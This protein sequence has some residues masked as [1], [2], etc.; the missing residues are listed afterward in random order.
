VVLKGPRRERPLSAEG[1]DEVLSGARRR[2]G[3]EHATCHELRHTCLTRLREA[4]MAL[5][6]VQA[7]ARAPQYRVHPRLPAQA[8][9]SFAVLQADG[10]RI[11]A[12]PP[13]APGANAIG[14]RIIGMLRRELFDWL[15]IVNEQY[16]H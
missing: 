5:E 11:L 13:Q 14:E 8:P 7:Q 12:S 6:V 9:R 16:L 10:I 3:P 4:G 2:A 1:L 15:L